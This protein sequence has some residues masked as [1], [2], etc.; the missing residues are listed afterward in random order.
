MTF[1]LKVYFGLHYN[2]IIMHE[3]VPTARG[4]NG[5]EIGLVCQ[6]MRSPQKTRLVWPCAGASHHNITPS[7]IMVNKWAQKRPK[8]DWS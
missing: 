8:P 4:Q 1:V 6:G 7:V 2:I 5:L 3:G